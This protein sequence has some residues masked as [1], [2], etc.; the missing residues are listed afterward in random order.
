VQAV[1]EGSRKIRVSWKQ[2]PQKQQNGEIESYNVHLVRSSQSDS[3]ANVISVN[4]SS[5]SVSLDQLAQFTEYRVWVLASTSVGDGPPSYPLTVK[6]DE[7]GMYHT[8]CAS[9]Q[10]DS[11]S[12]AIV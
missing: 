2:P 3:E 5:H 4:G 12:D 10:F 1:S 9:F 8:L 7:D 6:T 11:D